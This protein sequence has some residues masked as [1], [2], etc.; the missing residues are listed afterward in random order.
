MDVGAAY[1]T[2][3]DAETRKVY[4]HSGEEGVNKNAQRGGGQTFNGTWLMADTGLGSR[5]TRL[6]TRAAVRL[7]V[8]RLSY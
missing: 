2:L 4:D 1:E 3:S 5:V 6:F 7:P 8:T